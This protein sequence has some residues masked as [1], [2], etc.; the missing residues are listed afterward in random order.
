M[1]GSWPL[2]F[3][4]SSSSLSS[5]PLSSVLPSSSLSSI[6]APAQAPGQLFLSAGVEDREALP[7]FL[8]LVQL[9]YR[10]RGKDTLCMLSLPT[11]LPI[12]T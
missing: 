9:C 6:Q 12:H 5:L 4:S 1:D 2:D 3:S 7:L 11:P 8:A 10:D